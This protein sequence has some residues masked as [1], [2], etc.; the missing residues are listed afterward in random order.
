[1]GLHI[2]DVCARLG[3]RSELLRHL[4]A[5]VIGGD[6]HGHPPEA[7]A[8]HEGR[9]R[10]DRHA[11]P[12]GTGD[13][14]AHRCGVAGMPAAGHRRARDDGEHGLIVGGRFAVDGFAE[15]GVEIHAFTLPAVHRMGLRRVRALRARDRP[16]VTTP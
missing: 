2:A 7:G 11:E 6:G 5:E 12:L 14:H 16:R 13:R 1:M 8:I 3:E 15:I 10:P 9:M 4:G